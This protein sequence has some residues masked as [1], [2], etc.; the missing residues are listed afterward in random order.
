MTPSISSSEQQL[1]PQTSEFDQ[2][3]QNL[4]KRPKRKQTSAD[5]VFEE[6]LRKVIAI[7]DTERVKQDDLIRLYV[8]LERRFRS[9]T[10]TDECGYFPAD[11]R[12]A[13]AWVDIEIDP[14]KPDVHPVNIVRPDIR[15]NTNSMLQADVAVEIEARNQNALM[16]R[17]ADRWQKV[18]D[19]QRKEFL[20]EDL[21]SAFFDM[22]QKNGTV[23]VYSQFEKDESLTATAPQ[24]EQKQT[25]ALYQYFCSTCDRQGITDKAPMM[26]SEPDP[27]S[28]ASVLTQVQ[29]PHCSAPTNAKQI[30]PQ[31]TDDSFQGFSEF[32]AGD[33]RS[34]LI[35]PFFL[36]VDSLRT[37]GGDST[38]ARFIEMHRLKTRAELELEY[39]HFDFGQPVEWCYALKCWHA[40]TSGDWDGLWRSWMPPQDLADADIFEERV[41]FLSE[42]F[43]GGYIAPADYNFVGKD[44]QVKFSIKAGESMRDAIRRQFGKEKGFRFVWCGD[45]LVDVVTPKEAPVDHRK[46]FAFAH[47]L[48]NSTCF[49]SIPHLDS[50]KMGDTLTNLNTIATEFYARNTQT[51]MVA[52]SNYF[53][54]EDF[55]HDIVLTKNRALDRGI[56]DVVKTIDTP[57]LDVGLHNQ[58]QFT[59]EMR[60]ESSGVQPSMVGAPQPGETFSAQR[61]NLEQSR[62]LLTSPMKSYAQMLCTLTRQKMGI[63]KDYWTLEQFASVGAS[64]GEEWTEEDVA[65]MCDCDLDRDF[66]IEY[67]Q[68][69]EMPQSVLERE[70]KFDA[71]MQRLTTLMQSAQNYSPEALKQMVQKICDIADLDFDFN[72]LEADERVA[73]QRY[74]KIRAVVKQ[75]AVAPEMCQQLQLQVVAIDPVSGTV[76]SALDML[77]LEMLQQTGIRISAPTENHASA[78]A[79]YR[80]R[81]KTELAREQPDT[82]LIVC[83]EQMI[84]AHDKGSIAVNQQMQVKEIESNKPMM[85]L[86]QTAQETAEGKQKAQENENFERESAEKTKEREFKASEAE[87][88]HSRAKELENIKQTVPA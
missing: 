29:C 51:N 50:L 88:G 85:D 17:N 32:V 83:L 14:D 75:A 60:R 53:D 3:A 70:M 18:S 45:R 71:C 33:A 35:N 26:E 8:K 38:K 49:F 62:G 15:A 4:Q 36:T 39:P 57:K 66:T 73:T 28:V 34:E 69:S 84:M 40:L 16:E 65:E 30:Q 80:S 23:G 10:I 2:A 24:F 58:M 47:F 87:A 68:G 31:S 55:D 42:S 7:L 43:Y 61:Q 72:D 77:G 41:V 44:G 6:Y 13:M 59:L 54:R 48:P 20:K 12:Y 46:C 52:D 27:N 25:S 81:I 9:I 67:R 22:L 78:Q 76:T 86:E 63:A 79:F 74:R 1:Q 21:R 82:M 11:S 64:F 19:Y 56:Q 5:P 37:Q